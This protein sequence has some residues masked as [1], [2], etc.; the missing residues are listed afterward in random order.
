MLATGSVKLPIPGTEFGGRVIGTEEAWALSELPATMA[1]VGAGA[2]GT[3]I[4]SAYARLGVKVLLFEALDRVLPTED[5]DISK[6][7]E[8][9]FKRQGIE[10][11]TGTL[12]KDVKTGEQQRHVHLRRGSGR[13]RLARDRRRPRARRRR[14]RAGRRAASSSMTA[15]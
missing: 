6:V 8:R 4:A 12:V 3:E 2:S 13:G 5:A 7:A 1:V 14:A 9:G 15:A 10:V 11:H